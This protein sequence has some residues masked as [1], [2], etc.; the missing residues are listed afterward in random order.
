MIKTATYIA[1]SAWAP[2]LLNGDASGLTAAELDTCKA[3]RDS[4]T[5]EIVDCED[6]GFVWRHDA[7]SFMPL[8]ADCQAYTVIDAT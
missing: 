8:G 6:H 7:Y 3:W 1:P 2:Y 4:L 5:G